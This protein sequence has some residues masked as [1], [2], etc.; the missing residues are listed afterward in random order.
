[1]RMVIN[2]FTMIGRGL[3]LMLLSCT[4]FISCSKDKDDNKPVTIEGVWEGTYKYD[5]GSQT[6]K[7]GLNL[8]AGGVLEGLDAN[9]QVTGTGTWE[10]ENNIVYGTYFENGA[11]VTVIAAFYP[12]QKKLLG[13]WG[14]N[15]NVNEG[16]FDMTKKN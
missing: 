11:E 5:S 15:G 9:G 8:K 14:Y 2:S 3:A 7:W 10:I 6:F 16:T 13:D 1:M 4:L 12:E